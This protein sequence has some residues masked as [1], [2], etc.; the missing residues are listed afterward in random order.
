MLKKVPTH[1]RVLMNDKSVEIRI[2]QPGEKVEALSES[3]IPAKL[4]GARLFRED[5]DF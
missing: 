4:Q 2:V 3:I 5:E 1:A